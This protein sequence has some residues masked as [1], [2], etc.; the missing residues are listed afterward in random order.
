[1]HV[2]EM[3]FYYI[4]YCLAQTVALGFLLDSREDYADAFSRYLSFVRTG[5]RM[6]F[7]LL[8]AMAGL[9]SPFEKGALAAL[10]EKTLSLYRNLKKEA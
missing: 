3:P 1:M 6:A 7:P 9:P 8:V 5:G 10:A 4:D 2:Y